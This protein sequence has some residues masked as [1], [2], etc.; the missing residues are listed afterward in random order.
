M[1]NTK[2][3]QTKPTVTKKITVIYEAGHMQYETF[4][5]ICSYMFEFSQFHSDI[6]TR[7]QNAITQYTGRV[8]KSTQLFKFQMES[9]PSS[10]C[11]K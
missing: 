9:L 8:H 11:E 1:K 2:E 3:F 4:S 5:T 10:E 6:A 7:K